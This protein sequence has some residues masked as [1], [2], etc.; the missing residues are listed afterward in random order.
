LV[1]GVL[2]GYY[3]EGAM[4][5]KVDK[6]VFEGLVRGSEKEI[7]GLFKDLGIDCEFQNL[8]YADDGRYR[9]PR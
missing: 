6:S 8:Y 7:W 3:E 1:G 4:G 2:R 9:V 5:L